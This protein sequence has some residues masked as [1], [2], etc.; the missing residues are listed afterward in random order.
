MHSGWV[1][2]VCRD[3]TANR[4]ISRPSPLQVM[5]TSLIMHCSSQYSALWPSWLEGFVCEAAAQ[6]FGL[7]DVQL[8]RLGGRDEGQLHHR[9]WRVRYPEQGPPSPEQEEEEARR[10]GNG[11]LPPEGLVGL[12]QD[13][14]SQLFP[15]RESGAEC[16]LLR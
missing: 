6:L 4:L 11:T 15:F 3:I 9:T 10:V 8:E 2:G 16:V 1:A 12:V 13:S 14:F 7:A 5:P